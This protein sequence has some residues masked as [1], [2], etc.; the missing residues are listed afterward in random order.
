[1]LG[2]THS[3]T[4]DVIGALGRLRSNMGDYEAA[5]PLL[6]EALQMRQHT[7][8]ANHPDIAVNQR[9]LGGCLAALH[10]FAEARSLLLQ[11]Y[12]T[13]RDEQGADHQDTRRTLE[14]LATLY[15][16]WGKPERAE[17]MEARLAETAP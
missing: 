6:R 15:E 8:E 17:A 4:A 14:R 10:R 9:E 2:A 7:L 13:L 16:E 11:S 1:V 5:E 12:E 3:Q